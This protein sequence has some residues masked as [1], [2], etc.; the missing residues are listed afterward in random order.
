LEAAA[1]ANQ[2]RASCEAS[3]RRNSVRLHCH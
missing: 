2:K 3:H 1:D